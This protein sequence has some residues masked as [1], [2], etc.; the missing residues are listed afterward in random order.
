MGGKARIGIATAILEKILAV[1]A[2]QR[3]TPR[4]Y[5]RASVIVTT[6]LTFGE[7][8]LFCALHCREPLPDLVGLARFITDLPADHRSSKYAV[9]AILKRESLDVAALRRDVDGLLSWLP[10]IDTAPP[11]GFHGNPERG[12]FAQALGCSRS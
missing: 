11:R 2:E 4:L 8:L 9:L 12:I 7:W 3:K 5:E 6:N 10:L 1:R